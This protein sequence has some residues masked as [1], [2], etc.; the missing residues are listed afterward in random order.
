MY[1]YM[2]VQPSQ[3]PPTLQQS[4]IFPKLTSNY[5]GGKGGGWVLTYI[6]VYFWYKK[7]VFFFFF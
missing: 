6:Q 7:Y 3:L 1:T 2:S 4:P 5:G